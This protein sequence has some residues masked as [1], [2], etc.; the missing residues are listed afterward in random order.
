MRSCKFALCALFCLAAAVR[1]DVFYQEDFTDSE[2]RAAPRICSR[3]RFKKVDLN[4]VTAP[5]RYHLFI[6]DPLTLSTPM[7]FSLDAAV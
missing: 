2:Y 4:V 7:V 6:I 3:M 1:A 5:P